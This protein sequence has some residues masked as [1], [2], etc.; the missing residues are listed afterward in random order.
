MS[1][2]TANLGNSRFSLALFQGEKLLRQAAFDLPCDFTGAMRS[3][4]KDEAV[5][6]AGLCS[7]N[8]PLEESA[9]V[10]LRAYAKALRVVGKDLPVPIANLCQSPEKVGRD[11]LLVAYEAWQRVR[12]ACLVLDFGTAATLNAVSSRCEF[13]GGAIAPG[14]G[15]AARS[16]ATNTA[17]LPHA[18]LR[19]ADSIIARSTEQAIAAGIGWGWIGLCEK[20]IEQ[21]RAELG[22]DTIVFAT[23][24]DLDRLRSVKGIDHFVPHLLH[25]GL[26]RLLVS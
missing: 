11:R 26:R 21:G 17:Q 1:L 2:L 23:G 24:G 18:S 12:R 9:C 8:P 25:E 16:L 7:V 14:M 22:A 3:F 13:L 15:L 4:C 6:V 20:W 5:Q 19:E 10:A